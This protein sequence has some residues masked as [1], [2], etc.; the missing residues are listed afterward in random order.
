MDKKILRRC[1]LV[2]SIV[3]IILSIFFMFESYKMFANPFGKA[4]LP[5]EEIVKNLKLWYQS[6]GLLPLFVS[7]IL[8]LLSI[9]LLIIAIKDGARFDFIK[10]S[11]IISMKTNKEF[12]TCIE[13]L[14]FTAIYIYILMPVCR[15]FLDFFAA[16]QGFPFAIAT[17]I[18]ISGMAIYYQ[19]VRNK[20]SIRTSLLVGIAAAFMIAVLFNKLALIM[21]P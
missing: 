9:G 18:Y 19:P 14:G 11:N 12:R 10:I 4:T 7:G 13:V 6:P 5:E 21:L 20:K 3:F 15:A 8:L 2:T 17:S 16:F 1:D